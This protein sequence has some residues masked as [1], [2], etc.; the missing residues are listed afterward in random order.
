MLSLK[1]I[2]VEPFVNGNDFLN[3]CVLVGKPV[4]YHCKRNNVKP[5]L[6]SFKN[7]T[8]IAQRNTILHIFHMKWKFKPLTH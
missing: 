7:I 2:T 3:Y 6:Q 1:Y 5:S 4:R 8:L